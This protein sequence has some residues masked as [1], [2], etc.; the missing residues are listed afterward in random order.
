MIRNMKDKNRIVIKLGSSTLTHAETG[1]LNLR[2]MEKLVRIVT[3]LRGVGKDVVLVSSGAIAVGVQ[4]LGLGEKPGDLS[5][6]QALAAIGQAR[7]MMTYERL[8]S[9]YNQLSAQVLMTKNTVV[10][11]LSRFNATNT[12]ARL[13]E[14]GAVP[15]V[16]EN[17]TISTYEIQFGDNDRLSAI[18]AN[19]IDA[20]LL[21][22]LS[23]ID[24]M[25]TDD[26]NTNPDA[27]LIETIEQ[28]DASIEAMGKDSSSSKVGTG[29]MSAKIAAAT[30]ATQSGTDMVI[31]NGDDVENI[32]RILDG[33]NVGTLF[34]AHRNEAFDLYEFLTRE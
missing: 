5:S 34:K 15:I 12:F 16:N 32:S 31:A 25:Y 33:E 8:F 20:D 7:L 28:V 26:P 14:M 9:E 4:T 22:L 21:I 10:D 30:I 19:L 18:V 17:D 1:K 13:L 2:K 27:T 23:D 29:G 6:K 3:D 24:G 11:H